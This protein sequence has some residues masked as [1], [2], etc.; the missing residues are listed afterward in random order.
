VRK[1]APDLAISDLSFA[2][3]LDPQKALPLLLERARLHD[4][5][6]RREQALA[7]YQRVLEITPANEEAKAAVTRFKGQALRTD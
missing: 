4:T 7:D 2:I 1:G 3:T 5:L 6:N